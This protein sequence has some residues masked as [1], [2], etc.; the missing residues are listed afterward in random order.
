MLLLCLP[1]WKLEERYV[2]RYFSIPRD[3]VYIYVCSSAPYS[4]N[5][6][7]VFAWDWSCTALFHR[8][9][10]VFLECTTYDKQ[11][12]TE[13]TGLPHQVWS[14]GGSTLK[15]RTLKH[16]GGSTLNKKRTLNGHFSRPAETDPYMNIML[17]WC[18]LGYQT[19]ACGWQ[20]CPH[21]I[22]HHISSSSLIF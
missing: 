2:V 3:H 14:H 5:N 11:L 15:K 10:Q 19:V 17:L 7:V 20:V 21:N 16:Q 4:Q 9:N 22:N 1:I 6:L 8:S 13:R 18:Q 12:T